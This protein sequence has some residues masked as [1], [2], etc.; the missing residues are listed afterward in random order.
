MVLGCVQGRKTS[1]PPVPARPIERIPLLPAVVSLLNL[2]VPALPA[3][4][5][6]TH[7][8]RRHVRGGY[9]AEDADRRMSKFLLLIVSSQPE[10]DVG[11]AAHPDWGWVSNSSMR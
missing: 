6:N 8:A 2:V 1:Q 3:Q 7:A 9:S 10:G 4:G 11:L 5:L